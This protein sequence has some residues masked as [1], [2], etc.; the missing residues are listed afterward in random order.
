MWVPGAVA[1]LLFAFI[2][3]EPRYFGGW[4]ILLFAGAIC[5]CALSA[6]SRM[7]WTVGCI[8]LAVLIT[9]GAALTL[10][11]SR[12]AIGIDYAA[13]RTPVNPS[14]AVFLLNNGLN[15]QDAVAVIGDG[16]SAY[17]AHLARLHVVAEIPA[18][19]WVP[20]AHPAIDFWES[21]LD[22]QARALGILERTGVKAVI[23]YPQGDN[24]VPMP[25]IV[26]PPWKKIDGTGAYVYF[27]H[28]SP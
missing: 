14:I 22:Q 9:A 4:L 20:E 13:G 15:Q 26:P 18:A 5:A 6:D 23:A 12:E 25:S 16:A 19:F 27:F 11:A 17:W 28:T 21:G 7:R 2:H 24:T 10:Q 1:L 8:G 3:V